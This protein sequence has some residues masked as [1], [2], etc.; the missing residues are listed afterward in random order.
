MLDSG[1]NNLMELFAH[2]DKVF[3]LKDRE[4]IKLHVTKESVQNLLLD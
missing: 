1:I 2:H 3:L 4:L